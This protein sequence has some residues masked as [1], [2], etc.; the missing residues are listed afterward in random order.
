M[1]TLPTGWS[2]ITFV[3][4][5]T[6]A[7]TYINGVATGCT[8]TAPATLGSNSNVH[9]F[10]TYANSGN[11]AWNG[12][13]RR[14]RIYNCLLSDAQIK[15]DYSGMAVASGETNLKVE[16]VPQSM[17]V[18][19][20]LDTSGSGF[21]ASKSGS[22]TMTPSCKQI[23][24][25]NVGIGTT[26]PSAP[27]HVKGSVDGISGVW[28]SANLILEDSGGQYPGVSFRGSGNNEHGFI[29]SEGGAGLGFW[30]TV[31]GGAICRVLCLGEGGGARVCGT[32]C[33]TTSIA[34]A[35]N[36]SAGGNMEVQNTTYY[37]GGH[38]NNG[39]SDQRAM[40]L[41]DG[42]VLYRAATDYNHKMWYYDGLAFSTN[43]THGHFRFY[44][45]TNVSRGNNEGG[46]FLIFDIDAQNCITT[47]HGNLCATT[48]LYNTGNY[49][50]YGSGLD[51][52]T[53]NKFVIYADTTNH[54]LYEA[55]YVGST[56]R[57][58]HC[59]SWR[60]GP[61][62]GATSISHALLCTQG[63]ICASSLVKS[64]NVCA[65]NRVIASGT[66][67]PQIWATSSGT[68]A[69]T[70][71]YGD[72]GGTPRFRVQRN[73]IVVANS[74]HYWMGSFLLSQPHCTITGST[75]MTTKRSCCSPRS[76]CGTNCW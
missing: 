6:T 74:K 71:F 52:T 9:N 16:F 8:M 33:A 10:G 64:L 14:I 20:W 54:I 62:S 75:S 41:E 5:G 40:V 13:I 21:H 72:G 29:R 58:K 18:D 35:G 17:S 66:A 67:D 68:G 32:L 36:V 46:S 4:N 38:S 70:L 42:Q 26:S 3:K 55:P 25:G 12:S 50:Q 53:M 19:C 63:T 39:S 28:C 37:R 56:T 27:L 22:A 11:Q 7:C 76:T 30:T 44:G 49:H 43:C 34:S 15:D 23:F 2:H 69:E 51:G 48:G 60:G 45:D 31:N 24:G 65:T 61:N 59:F 57:L 47:A 1:G 73:G